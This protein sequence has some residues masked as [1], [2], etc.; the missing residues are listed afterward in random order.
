[1]S[2]VDRVG[3]LYAT[4]ILGYALMHYI[5]FVIERRKKLKV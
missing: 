1:M 5:A 3:Y 2:G 4:V